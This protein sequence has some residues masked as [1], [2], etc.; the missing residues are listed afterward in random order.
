M[1]AFV[2]E[3]DTINR[4]VWWLSREAFRSPRLKISLE[5]TL[6]INTCSATWEQ[7]LGQAMFQ[8]NIDA[9]N[10]RYGQGEAARFRDL[11]YS[12]RPG[13]S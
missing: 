10:D 2:V 1:S 3:D 6:G 4:I 7:E 11:T 5:H 13:Q 8:L 9:V 12:Y